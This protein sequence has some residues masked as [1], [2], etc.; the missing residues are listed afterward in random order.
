MKKI[1]IIFITL[2]IFSVLF[3]FLIIS[4]NQP[5]KKVAPNIIVTP[6]IKVTQELINKESV[7]SLYVVSTKPKDEEVD[8]SVSEKIVVTFNRSFAAQEIEFTIIPQLS[9][10]ISILQ[11]QLIISPKEVFPPG[12]HYTF[13]IKY[14]V[15]GAL[16]RSYSFTVIGPTKKFKP[17]T[18]PQNAAEEENTFQR[19]NHPDVFLT[20]KSPYSNEFFG[21]VANY[22]KGSGKYYFQVTLKGTDKESSKQEFN[23]WLLNLGL[24]EKQIKELDIR[25]L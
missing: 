19:Q 18:F 2:I 7:K 21:I 22:Q 23:K 1:I 4:L 13:V 10:E 17:D 15:L 3:S 16:P 14:P 12:E 5:E 11:N 6:S 24:T 9:Y 25:Y 8:I 20:N